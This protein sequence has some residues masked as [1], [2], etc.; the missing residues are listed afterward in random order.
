MPTTGTEI[1]SPRYKHIEIG[2][3]NNKTGIATNYKLSNVEGHVFT[4]QAT[5][6]RGYQTAEF[7]FKGQTVFL[8]V[9]HLETSSYESVKVAQA[10]ELFDLVQTKNTFILAGDFNTVCKSTSDTEYATI[11]KQFI[12]AGYNVG[13]CSEQ[14]GFIDTWTAGSTEI[15]TWYPCDHIITSADFIMSDVERDT[16]KIAEAEEQEKAI[17]HVAFVCTLD[18]AD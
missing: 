15:G 14:H 9:A 11:M 18:F 6:T 13:N 10:Q 16:I 5:E 12:D 7:T 3:Q 17:D 8:V 1:L 4:N 2:T